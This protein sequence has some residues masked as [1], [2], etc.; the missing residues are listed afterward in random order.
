M[1]TELEYEY[2][3]LVLEDKWLYRTFK[4]IDDPEPFTIVGVIVDRRRGEEGRRMDRL[5]DDWGN[6]WFI[7]ELED[8]KF[9][10]EVDNERSIIY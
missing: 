10:V 2:R 6:I 1:M 4:F 3:K 5:Q 9:L 8:A 7:F